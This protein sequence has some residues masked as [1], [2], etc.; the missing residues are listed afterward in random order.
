MW[1]AKSLRNNADST[2][3]PVMNHS[4]RQDAGEREG[5]GHKNNKRISNTSIRIIKRNAIPLLV[6]VNL[7]LGLTAR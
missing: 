1:P 5:I 2:H 7:N 3:T 6:T 4:K